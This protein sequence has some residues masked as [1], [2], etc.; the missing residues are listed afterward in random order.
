MALLTLL[1]V[2]QFTHLNLTA[3]ILRGHRVREGKGNGSKR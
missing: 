2:H 1:A 3:G